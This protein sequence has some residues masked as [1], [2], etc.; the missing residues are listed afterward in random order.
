MENNR[1]NYSNGDGIKAV[2]EQKH[3][4]RAWLDQLLWQAGSRTFKPYSAIPKHFLVVVLKLGNPV[5]NGLYLTQMTQLDGPVLQLNPWAT[6]HS[7]CQLQAVPPP[8]SMMDIYY[9]LVSW[10]QE[11]WHAASIQL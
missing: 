7:A 2:P 11:F 3:N 6:S 10:P 1:N 4:N 9:A 5:T 8:C